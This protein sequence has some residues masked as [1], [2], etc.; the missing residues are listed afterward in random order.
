MKR[1]IMLFTVC[2]VILWADHASAKLIAFE[3][4][5][6]PAGAINGQNGGS[7]FN[8]VWMSGAGGQV[9]EG[10]LQG[11][12]GSS[13]GNKLEI[14]AATVTRPSNF[15]ELNLNVNATNYLSILVSKG[16]SAGRSGEN[17]S[18]KLM[19][20]TSPLAG[21]SIGSD[22]RVQ[23]NTRL[24]ASNSVWS[25]NAI[26]INTTYL[27]V[28]KLVTSSTAADEF[29]I[30]WFKAGDLVPANPA[31]ITWLSY[32]YFN[33]YN[34]AATQLSILSGTTITTIVDEFK[35]SGDYADVVP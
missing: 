1:S 13:S 24:S 11:V 31:N 25:A 9:T 30:A 17:V 16:G 7:G 29:S 18:F 5:D 2:I 8:G 19:A 6:C 10:S 20:G 32:S 3:N 34:S 26:D 4:F 21:F 14:A 12:G 15:T 33:N 22:E 35:L 27:F 28:M 23:V